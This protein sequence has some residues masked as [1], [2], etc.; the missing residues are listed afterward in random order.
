M[1]WQHGK[2]R[3]FI[4]LINLNWFLEIHLKTLHPPSLCMKNAA[5][6]LK[7]KIC[8]PTKMF[9][10]KQLL[11]IFELARFNCMA[12]VTAV[13]TGMCFGFLGQ[14]FSFFQ[15]LE[16]WRDWSATLGAQNPKILQKYELVVLKIGQTNL[17]AHFCQQD[18]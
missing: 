14:F 3:T 10:S 17:F 13:C 15:T 2:E 7:T 1:N 4:F 11:L 6:E 8:C 16:T 9:F 18:N 5:R 12:L